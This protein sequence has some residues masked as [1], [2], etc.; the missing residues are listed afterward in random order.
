M[1]EAQDIVAGFDHAVGQLE[2]VEILGRD[3]L[4]GHEMVADVADEVLPEI[5]PGFIDEDQRNEARLAGLHEGDDFH[6][7]VE[8]AEAAGGK[9]RRALAS[10]RKVSLR[11]KK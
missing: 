10:R 9:R 2:E 3:E 11:V 7:F 6:A 8:G 4:V 1:I 5:A